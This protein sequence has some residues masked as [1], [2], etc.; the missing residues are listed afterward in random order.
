VTPIRYNHLKEQGEHIMDI[1][2]KITWFITTSLVVFFVLKFLFPA[3][4]LV[5][6]FLT[7]F[8]HLIGTIFPK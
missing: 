1:T 4:E 3:L 8:F 2:G 7:G 5:L 6:G